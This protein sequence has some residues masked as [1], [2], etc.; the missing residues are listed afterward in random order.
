[1]N[2]YLIVS[3]CRNEEDLM[4]KTLDSVCQQSILPK[5]WI[6]VDDGSIGETPKILEKY[7]NQY[8]FMKI[9]RRENRGHRSW[10][11]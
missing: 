7:A 2:K 4:R 8:D 5:K 9:I 1:M 6:I 3:P 11:H 10:R